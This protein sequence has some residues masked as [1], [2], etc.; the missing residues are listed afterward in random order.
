ML[1]QTGRSLMRRLSLVLSLLLAFWMISLA[2][3]HRPV[4]YDE[5]FT[6]L[7][8]ARSPLVALFVYELPNNHLIHSFGVW[9]TTS[10]MG[11]SLLAIRFISLASALLCAAQLIRLTS[12]ISN[13]SAGLLAASFL[14]VIPLWAEMVANARGYTLSAFLTLMFIEMIYFGGSAL[15]GKKKR[16]LMGICVLLMLTLPTMALLIAAGCLW[17]IWRVWNTQRRR[18]TLT[19]YLPPI[20]VGTLIGGLF[21]LTVFSYGNASSHATRFGEDGLIALIGAWT[22]QVFTALPAVALATGVFAGVMVLWRAHRRLAVLFALILGVVIV[23]SLAQ[24]IVTGRVF[25]ARNFY[26]LIPLTA[27][28]GG[29]G[30]AW[31]LRPVAVLRY[32]SV[33]VLLLIGI[34]VF[35]PLNEP[36]EASLLAAAIETETRAGDVVLVSCCLDYPLYYTHRQRQELFQ[37]TPEVKRVV[38]I[39]T[40]LAS[41][42]ELMA[43]SRE[44]GAPIAPET[45]EQKRWGLTEITICLVQ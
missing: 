8:Y 6:Y 9:L 43:Y 7:R 38:F 44:N 14:T 45:C 34:G 12:R 4:Q 15:S 26:Y 41:L 24:E 10:I 16:A 25:F 39:P 36:T 33:G 17:M 2:T 32:V 5:A 37:L 35:Q 20:V 11:N 40:A 27:L 3:I 1:D 21:Y 18:L 22:A 29:V 31:L 23:I 13:L 42:E 28:L 30:I 19:N